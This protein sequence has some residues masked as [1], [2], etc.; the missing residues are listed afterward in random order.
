MPLPLA[1][2]IGIGIGLGLG[3]LAAILWAATTDTTPDLPTPEE[4]AQMDVD[5]ANR[6][7]VGVTTPPG[8]TAAECNEI[9]RLMNS[10]SNQ[11]SPASANIARQ[12]QVLQTWLSI[13]C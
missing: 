9:N 1:I 11:M 3:A 10:A 7:L 13:N 6:V 12:I 4:L 2:G 5:L 8:A